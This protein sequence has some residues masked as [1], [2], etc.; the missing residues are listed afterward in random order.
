VLLA[1]LEIGRDGADLVHEGSIADTGALARELHKLA[2]LV[3]NDVFQVLCTLC[4]SPE[5]RGGDWGL[6]RRKAVRD[7][8]GHAAVR[9]PRLL[10]GGVRRRRAADS[11]AV[12]H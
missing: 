2:L 3:G 6:P 12:L 5:A 4:E 10:V 9:G 1:V 11:L 7:I 8:V